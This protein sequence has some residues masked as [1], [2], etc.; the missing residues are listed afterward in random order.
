MTQP[1][2]TPEQVEALNQTF[3]AIGRTL[4]EA[5]EPIAAAAR[6]IGHAIDQW[7]D[8]FR[9]SWRAIS[10]T[11]EQQLRLEHGPRNFTDDGRWQSDLC[12]AWIHG[13]CPHPEL[14]HCCCTC[15]GGDMR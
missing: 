14:S 7:F 11:V 13:S 5:F 1:T 10:L 9:I 12:A 8:Q 2:I 4:R 3:R 15:H 6:T